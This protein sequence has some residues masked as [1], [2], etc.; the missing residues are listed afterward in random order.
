MIENSNDTGADIK[1]T[2]EENIRL[3]KEVEALKT[4][5]A[6]LKS[7]KAGLEKMLESIGEGVIAVDKELK[8]IFANKMSASICGFDGA[9]VMGSRISEVFKLINVTSRK[10]TP[11]PAE[12]TLQTLQIV[13]LEHNSAIVT[14]CGEEKFLSASSAP[15]LDEN[16]NLKG[17]ILVFRDISDRKRMEEELLKMSKLEALGVL[18]GG[19]AHDFNNLLTGITGNISYAKFIIAEDSPAQEALNT[20]EQIAFK[21]KDLTSQFRTFSKGGAPVKKSVHISESLKPIVEF[22]LRGSR[23]KTL[24]NIDKNLWPAEIDEGQINQLITNIVINAVQAMPNGGNLFV[25]AVN[26]LVDKGNSMNLAAGKYVKFSFRDEG[27][28][29]EAQ[30]LTKIFDPY[31]ST[32]QT[33]SGLGL[34]SSYSIV[35]KH[36]GIITAESVYGS[37]ATFNVFLPASFE[38]TGHFEPDSKKNKSS[39][40]GRKILVM[41]DESIVREVTSNL[42]KHLGYEVHTVNNGSEAIASFVRAHE[43][44]RPFD[45]LILDLI[46][47]GDLGGQEV[48]QKLNAQG[49]SAKAIAA[50]GFSNETIMSEYK[51]YGFC[52]MIS[53]PYKI[54]E[55]DEMIQKIIKE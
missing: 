27:H 9:K 31:Y 51:R 21:A 25:T 50:S 8:V 4:E 35:R 15:I 42:L 10:E 55:L 5:I 49:L 18:A 29:I 54:K 44:N 53:K 48:L 33:G 12:K 39:S 36:G 7:R 19:I 17:A 24:F 28:G 46:V 32:R 20:A 43:E 16:Q 11:N 37:G 34:T 40:A 22:A 26:E 6:D 41:D 38:G 3:A 47:P 23:V 1:S 52:A 14:P 2:A 45:A 13:G 30:D